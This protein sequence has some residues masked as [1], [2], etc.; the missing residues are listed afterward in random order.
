M[1][2]QKLQKVFRKKKQKEDLR[3]FKHKCQPFKNQ[4]VNKIGFRIQK[5]NVAVNPG[6]QFVSQ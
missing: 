2:Q 5:A 6:E 4:N 1:R 3:I